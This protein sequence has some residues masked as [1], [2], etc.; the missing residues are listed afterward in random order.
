M[1]WAHL[2]GRPLD[3]TGLNLVS[4]PSWKI[5]GAMEPLSGALGQCGCFKKGLLEE[6]ILALR[7]EE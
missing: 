7:F 3:E 4:S 1:V 2:Q 6:G 5:V